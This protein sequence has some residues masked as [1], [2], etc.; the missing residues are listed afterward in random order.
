M[1]IHDECINLFSL[2][3]G[4]EHL[5]KHKPEFTC[6]TGYEGKGSTV[7]HLSCHISLNSSS[8]MHFLLSTQ[9]SSHTHKW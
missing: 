2:S 1:R 5:Q 3:F 8:Y 6:H 9:F 7:D 4:W